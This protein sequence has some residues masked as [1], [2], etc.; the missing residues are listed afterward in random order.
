MPIDTYVE[1]VRVSN[2]VLVTSAEMVA[3]V[4]ST[5]VVVV[6]ATIVSLNRMLTY[7]AVA[8]DVVYTVLK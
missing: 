5:C 2:A 3:V 6:V 4:R 1:P 7:E 8:I